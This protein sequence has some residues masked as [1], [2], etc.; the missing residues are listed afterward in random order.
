MAMANTLQRLGREETTHG[1]RSSFRDWAA[2]RTSFA[3]EIC[4][5]SL[6]HRVAGATESAYWR[7]DIV[8][9]RRRLMA[10]WAR[11]CCSPPAA[12]SENVVALRGGHG[13]E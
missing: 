5:M 10:D 1:F 12:T 6:A 3:R 2:E 13:H 11:F 7:S 9:K 8:E 4:E